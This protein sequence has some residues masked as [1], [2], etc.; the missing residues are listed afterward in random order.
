MKCTMT[1]TF[2]SLTTAIVVLLVATATTTN[3]NRHS[4][5]V[6][7]AQSVNR[8]PTTCPQ[9]PSLH[10]KNGST[11]TE[12]IASFGKQHD[13]LDLQTH[14]SG[15]Y[16]KCIVGFIGHECGIQVDD[17]DGDT[18]YNPSDPTGVLRSCY[19][20]STCQS[21]GNGVYCDCNKLNQDRGPMATKLAGLMCQH[22]STSLC[23]ASLVGEHAP[24]HQFCTNHGKCV[25]IVT[26]GDPHP[27]CVC[28]EGWMGDHCEVRQDQLLA[29]ASANEGGGNATAGKVLFSLLI[30]AMGSVVTAILVILVKGKRMMDA[31]GDS[32]ADVQG[33]EPAKKTVLGEGDL[34][35]DGSG[36]LGN[37]SEDTRGDVSDNNDDA[38]GDMELTL[39][40][41]DTSPADS[42]EQEIV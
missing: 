16:C 38:D 29:M 26:G 37:P 8:E 18:G 27:G 30:I 14:E 19:H 40:E 5:L 4:A 25:K 6:V 3:N 35:P 31:N 13:H 34:D 15:Y 33:E 10:C 36:T 24:N 9:V 17:C 1:M 22:E 42:D 7:A 41:E 32:S 2:Q 21:N 28:R 39:K 23:A 11:C 20:G 12:G